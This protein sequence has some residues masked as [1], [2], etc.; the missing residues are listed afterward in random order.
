MS[1]PRGH[2]R[3]TSAVVSSTPHSH[4][5]H[6]KVSAGTQ[7]LT[8]AFGSARRLTLSYCLSTTRIQVVCAATRAAQFFCTYSIVT[9]LDQNRRLYDLPRT[10][11]VQRFKLRFVSIA[12]GHTHTTSRIHRCWT[13]ARRFCL[14]DC[15][16]D[17]RDVGEAYHRCAYDVKC[18]VE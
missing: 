6:T 15:K 3:C 11:S 10:A 18:P 8:A 13:R 4:W 9:L 1:P 17:A 5:S 7:V 2:V 12:P 14:S 16:S